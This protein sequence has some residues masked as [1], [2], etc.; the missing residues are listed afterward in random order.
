MTENEKKL[1][2]INN[3]RKIKEANGMNTEE[4]ELEMISIVLED[5]FNKCTKEEIEDWHQEIKKTITEFS[6]K[7]NIV[8]SEA[9]E[10][11]VQQLWTIYKK[12]LEILK[13]GFNNYKNGK[14]NFNDFQKHARVFCYILD[15]LCFSFKDLAAKI[16]KREKY[17][18]D[19]IPEYDYE[20]L[21]FDKLVLEHDFYDCQN[22]DDYILSVVDSLELLSFIEKFVEDALNDKTKEKCTTISNVFMIVGT[23]VEGLYACKF[24]N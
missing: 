12:E 16:A 18:D 23:H 15:E 7:Y 21:T 2:K 13:N 22:Y 20:E 4:E 1:L 24:D 14:M 3:K 17:D 11:K 5:S 9:L 6:Q 19:I 10:F 8:L